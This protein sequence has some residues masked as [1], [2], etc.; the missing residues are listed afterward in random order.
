M[1]YLYAMHRKCK[2]LRKPD[3]LRFPTLVLQTREVWLHL[4]TFWDEELSTWKCS[5]PPQNLLSS[6]TLL[7]LMLP[8]FIRLYLQTRKIRSHYQ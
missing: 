1:R 2:K 8:C 3:L 4:E 6:S 5:K 7:D